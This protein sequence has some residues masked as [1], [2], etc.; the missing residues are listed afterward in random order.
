LKTTSYISDRDNRFSLIM[1][2]AILLM[3]ATVTFARTQLTLDPFTAIKDL[4]FK[5]FFLLFILLFIIRA[6]V[7]GETVL[8]KTSLL[9]PSAIFLAIGLLS[10]IMATNIY[11][12]KDDFMKWF[13]A[14]LFSFLLVQVKKDEWLV[15]LAIVSSVVGLIVSGIAIYQYFT[16]TSVNLATTV[17]STLGHSNFLSHYLVIIIPLTL[18]LVLS[19]EKIIHAIFF[20]IS[21]IVEI[22]ALAVTFT[23]GGWLACAGS[24]FVFGII[25]WKFFPEKKVFTIRRLVIA[26]ILLALLIGAAVIEKPHIVTSVFSS[27]DS[28]KEASPDEAEIKYKAATVFVRLEMWKGTWQMIKENPILGIGLGNYWI[29]S[30]KYRTSEE[31]SIDLDILQWAHNDFLQIGAETGFIG[32]AAFIFLIFSI[33]RNGFKQFRRLEGASK[34]I[35][36]A[37]ICGIAA[38]IMHSM[39]SFNF[40]KTVP[41]MYFW[42]AAGFL[43]NKEERKIRF[44]IP[45]SLG[46]KISIITVASA[47]V[48]FCGYSFAGELIGEYYFSYSERASVQKKWSESIPL[49]VKAIN[50]S[51]HNAK[52]RYALG[53]SY[54]KTG[55]F[56]G[57]IEQGNIAYRLTPYVSDVNRLLCYVYNEIGNIYFS[58]KDY[59]PALKEYTRVVELCEERKKIKLRSHELSALDNE[60]ANAYYNR[61]NAYLSMSQKEKARQ[62]YRRA[63]Q[64]NPEHY[65]ALQSLKKLSK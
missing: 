44:S 3:V 33:F 56:E 40:Y 61:G 55:N 62:D 16:A 59:D 54:Y 2:I 63:F 32:L 25:I 50:Y 20:F 43:S 22:A 30:Q 17:K 38:T 23:R 39:V 64:Y 48:L 27:K 1:L 15:P 14:V 51:P 52:L 18:A 35:S 31:R 47:L 5:S 7:S 12:F 57:A 6:V 45:K 11:V 10:G 26:A 8:H 41:F 29:V 53:L 28:Y 36:A 4:L 19:A 46:I 24:L 13:L 49:L 60:I 42:L 65:Y 58:G 37:L 21:F 34:T 9:L